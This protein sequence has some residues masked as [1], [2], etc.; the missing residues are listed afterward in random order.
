VIVSSVLILHVEDHFTFILSIIFILI[1]LLVVNASDAGSSMLSTFVV[2]L[3]NNW[4][5]IMNG[6]QMSASNRWLYLFFIVM[7]FL[8]VFL[9]LNII[10]SIFVFTFS[11]LL[12]HAEFQKTAE[13]QIQRQLDLL[14]KLGGGTFKKIR[15]APRLELLLLSGPELN[16]EYRRWLAF[17][18]SQ[19]N[20][21]HNYSLIRFGSTKLGAHNIHNFL[22]VDPD[23][24]LRDRAESGVGS[25]HVN[26]EDLKQFLHNQLG[27]KEDQSNTML[28]RMTSL[29]SA[30]RKSI[31]SP[32][33]AKAST[34]RGRRKNGS[35]TERSNDTTD[36]ESTRTK[37]TP[38][39]SVRF[40]MEPV[41]EYSLIEQAPSSQ[42]L[43]DGDELETY[44]GSEPRQFT[45]YPTSSVT[46]DTE[47][48][49]KISTMASE[50]PLLGNRISEIE[51]E[52]HEAGP[53][54][55]EPIPAP[56]KEGSDEGFSD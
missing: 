16:L 23:A 24:G 45:A 20:E 2:A 42:V 14:H 39:P 13:F 10:Q 41:R 56:E 33:V 11:T 22:F 19:K 54:P 17:V 4:D 30:S 7:H 35:F 15:R 21:S 34:G 31:R 12:N 40:N 43:D 48:L 9:L 25:V 18:T 36:L 52:M 28:R 37:G 3:G 50:E 26:Q 46:S 6:A 38:V 1:C 47:L 53:A 51:L 27:G 55:L 29:V 8:G 32:M 49:K 44:N 5:A